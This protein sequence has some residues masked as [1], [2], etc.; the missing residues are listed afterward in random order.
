VIDLVSVTRFAMVTATIAGVLLALAADRI[1]AFPRR[2]RVAFWASLTVALVPILPKPLPTVVA[3]PLPPFIADGTWRS[4][5]P[6]GRTLVTVPLPEVTSGRVGMRWAALSGLEFRVPRGY[7]M[8]PSVDGTGSWNAPRRFTSD[9]INQILVYGAQPDVSDADRQAVA[10]D[11][12]FWRAAVVVLVPDAPHEDVLQ[13]TFTS[14]FGRAPQLVGGVE[15]W[16]VPP[17]G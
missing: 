7:F 2:R 5:V 4:Y 8:G 16:A 14:V 15:L 17:T 11:L 12:R 6:A 1:G 10:A 3:D 9:L 13:A